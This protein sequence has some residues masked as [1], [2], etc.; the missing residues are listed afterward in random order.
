M[1]PSELS[2]R[3]GRAVRRL[4][5]AARLSQETLAEAAGLHATHVSLFERGRGMP[6]L[7]VI[8]GLAAGLGLTMAGL[9]AAVEHDDPAEDPP[10]IPRGR[11]KRPGSGKKPPRSAGE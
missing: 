11:P 9:M 7:R 8:H 3:F 1:D 2:T 10:P 6:T 4:R 5:L